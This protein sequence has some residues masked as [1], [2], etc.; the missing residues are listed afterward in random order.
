MFDSIKK[1][2]AQM[3]LTLG[4]IP[5]I[6][7]LVKSVEIPGNGPEKL[8]VVTDLIALC[9]DM[10]PD[11]VKQAIGLQKVEDFVVK[12]VNRVVEFLTKAGVF[13]TSKPI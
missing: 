12:V 7:A 5:D 4:L 3:Q 1:A 9:W 2:L 6:I 11:A 10:I 13:K 8:S